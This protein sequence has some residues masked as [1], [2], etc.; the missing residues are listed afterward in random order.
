MR[1]FQ[2]TNDGSLFRHIRTTTA[3]H[4]GAR[5]ASAA[6]TTS[7]G[8][9][10]KGCNTTARGRSTPATTTTAKPTTK[11][12][13]ATTTTARTPTTRVCVCVSVGSCVH[14]LHHVNPRIVT[15]T[16]DIILGLVYRFAVYR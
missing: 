7:A 4:G 16:V 12:T 11:I 2:C 3:V 8:A 9:T 14:P 5:T 6:T 10:T 13:P 1:Q 15:K